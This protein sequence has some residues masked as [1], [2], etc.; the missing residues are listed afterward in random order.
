MTGKGYD[1]VIRMA[2]IRMSSGA[3][4]ALDDVRLTVGRNE[5]VGLLGDNGAGV[6]TPKTIGAANWTRAFI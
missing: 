1:H 2:N 5:I 3:V 4:L 6:V